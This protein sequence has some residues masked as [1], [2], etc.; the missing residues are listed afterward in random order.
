MAGERY[1]HI[2][3]KGAASVRGY[4]N[5]IVGGSSRGL[6]DRDRAT[7]STYLQQRLHAAW[8]EVEECQ[9]VVHVERYG[10]YIEFTGEPG[11]DLPITS[12]ESRRSGIRLLNVRNEKVDGG[13]RTLATVYVP[14][15]RRGHFLKKIQ[16]YATEETKEKRE[17][18]NANLVNS[19][20][21][22]HRAVLKSFWRVDEQASM[23][24]EE[25]EWVEVWLSSDADD[26]IERFEALLQR[27]E[28]R[29]TDGELRFP[30]RAV[31]MVLVNRR[32]IERLIEESDDI[33]ELRIAKEVAS[34]FIEL[35]NR[36]QL[37]MVRDLLTRTRVDSDRDVAVTVLDSGVNNG[38]LLIKPILADEDL[39]SPRHSEW[40]VSD[41]RG[42]GT[43]MAGTAAYGDLLALLNSSGPVR[44]SHCLES[45]KIL[46]PPRE[47]NPRHL[48]GYLTAQGLSLAEIQAPERKRIICMAVTSTDSRDRGRP[49][50]WSACPGS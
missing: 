8:M 24:G 27:H 12:L 17:P 14:H 32:H 46:P 11:F 31:V 37:A 28:I 36:E 18:K 22:I 15:K 43:L 7:H 42:H 2:F 16:A 21:D 29:R 50:S 41:D 33:A 10:A 4:T 20:S 38:H 23:P 13:E 26:V 19:I 44:I 48:W 25:P 9:A 1:R 45:V 35:E 3:L 30:E 47:Q 40:G 39:H 5:P 6:P 34:F 49:S